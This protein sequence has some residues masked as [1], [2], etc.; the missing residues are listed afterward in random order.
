[1]IKYDKLIY[2]CLAISLIFVVLIFFY[3][4]NKKTS[5]LK[6]EFEKEILEEKSLTLNLK[7]DE[8]KK[9]SLIKDI[10]Y[11][12]ID[13]FGNKFEIKAVEAITDSKNL[14]KIFLK[15]V[16]A[17]IILPNSELIFIKSETANYNKDTLITNFIDKVEIK[18]LDH[19]INSEELDLLF[20]SRIANIRNNVIYEGVDSTL[21]TDNIVVNFNNNSSKVFMN[22]KNKKIKINSK[23]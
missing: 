6:T 16:N 2:V 19:K 15:T 3:N 18:Y 9:D 1:M 20:K 21:E 13:N 10:E 7:N 23:Y 5:D 22:T 8:N 14:N 17:K 12:S 11:Y 4:L